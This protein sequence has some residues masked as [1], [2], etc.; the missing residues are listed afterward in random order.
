MDPEG[1]ALAYAWDFG[2]G[3]AGSGA[4]PSHSYAEVGTYTATVTVTDA[5]G[6]SDTASVEVAAQVCVDGAMNDQ[7]CLAEAARPGLA[8][9]ASRTA[10]IAPCGVHF[11]AEGLDALPAERPLHELT[12]QWRFGDE[13][14]VYEA[15]PE[16]FPFGRDANRAQ[17]PYAGHVFEAPGTYTV[18][19]TATARGRHWAIATQD[20]VVTDP[21]EAFA[22]D[23]TVCVSVAGDF[24]GCPAGAARFT[25][26]LLGTKAARPQ[27]ESRRLMF[28]AGETF[29]VPESTFWLRQ[30]AVHVT[31]FGDGAKPVLL[32]D[33]LV[34]Q[35]TGQV[36]NG[37]SV[38]VF[39]EVGEAT[40]TGLDFQGSYDAAT[41]EGHSAWY[42]TVQNITNLDHLT[43]FR[44][45]TSGFNMA[46]NGLANLG[47]IA[48]IDNEVTNWSNFGAYTANDG[49]HAFVG[50]SIKQKA[51]AVSGDDAKDNAFPWWADHGPL[52]FSTNYRLALG[53]NDLF[54]NVGWSS[55]GKAHQPNFR[56]NTGGADGHSG[57]L[58]ENRMTGGFSVLSITVQNDRTTAGA[59]DVIVE[60]N[61]LIGTDNTTAMIDGTYGG[62]TIR[63]NLLVMPDHETT[64]NQH[65]RSMWWRTDQSVP[66][67]GSRPITVEHN[68]VVNLQS[69]DHATQDLE[70]F[71]NRSPEFFTDLTVRA[72]N[73]YAPDR[74]NA[75]AFD[76]F[77]PFDADDAHR[78]LPGNAAIGSDDRSVHTHDT[79]DGRVRPTGRV[80]QGATEPT[81]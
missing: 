67:N 26:Y 75:F 45:R 79:Y 20:I 54:S 74:T 44:N 8:I 64:F 31:A 32:V 48:F 13:G 56:Y 39:R 34:V 7:L 22:G 10:C 37:G 33:E 14:S 77:T 9:E 4:R 80:T 40:V 30:P 41:G 23:A 11:S 6:L 29:T 62:T 35:A 71:Q 5:G 50:N 66:E 52:R 28:R 42:A 1:G 17:G 76:N 60:R 15:L 72:N 81:R 2:D 36:R 25:D 53:R 57:V 43:Y 51:D 58:S 61:E 55:L 12:Y 3:Q 16:D 49:Y 73:V 65:T 78:P 24:D 18:Q 69:S 27:G 63:N 70:L 19:L 38:F 47:P 21:D 68:T 46:V 59:G